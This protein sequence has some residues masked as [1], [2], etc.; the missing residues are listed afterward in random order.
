MPHA[1]ESISD[2][3]LVSRPVTDKSAKLKNTGNL[4]T[5]R[6]GEVMEIGS[7]LTVS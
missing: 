3:I 7:F 4:T 5:L 6:K 2:M 1:C